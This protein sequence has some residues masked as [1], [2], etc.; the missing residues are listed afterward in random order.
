[1]AVPLIAPQNV[2]ATTPAQP[3]CYADSVASHPTSPA[4]N[5][6]CAVTPA[7]SVG[8]GGQLNMNA[9]LTDA[10]NNVLTLGAGAAA[11]LY[12]V[13]RY[14]SVLSNY[15]LNTDHPQT[16]CLRTPPPN[17]VTGTYTSCLGTRVK[18]NLINQNF[19]VIRGDQV[20]PPGPSASAPLAYGNTFA[21][22]P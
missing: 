13:C 22:Q 9:T 10:N 12:Q 11:N 17:P 7:S 5:Y 21:H 19:L 2:A 8:W 1:M 14:T 6:Y 18:T 16:Y 4:V 3:Q 15:T 20:C